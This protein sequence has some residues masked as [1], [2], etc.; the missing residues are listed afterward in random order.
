MWKEWK[1]GQQKL[2]NKQ[3]VHGGTMHD[4]Q[5]TYLSWIIL[6]KIES[7]PKEKLAFKSLMLIPICL[8]YFV[9]DNEKVRRE[10]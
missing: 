8:K 5:H 2:N 7:Y 4:M 9:I 10:T 1:G 6:I 3:S